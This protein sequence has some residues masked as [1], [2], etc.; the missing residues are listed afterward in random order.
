MSHAAKKKL[1]SLIIFRYSIFKMQKF[2]LLTAAKV[3][4]C[5]ITNEQISNI[6]ISLN[7][8]KAHGQAKFL[9]M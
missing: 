5:E 1:L 3:D 4:S 6:L 2:Y 7:V 8:K 9:L